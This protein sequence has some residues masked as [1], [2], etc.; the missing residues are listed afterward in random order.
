[1][2]KG[3]SMKK[4]YFLLFILFSNSSNCFGQTP[5]QTL[6]PPPFSNIYQKPILSPYVFLDS[7]F[8]MP[9]YSR[10]QP[11]I[12]QEKQQL[13]I[14]RQNKKISKLQNEIVHPNKMRST[15][16]YSE[17]YNNRINT[18]RPTGHPTYFMNLP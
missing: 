16:Q 5:Y 18:I 10:V 11:L 9:Y 8:S 6:N 1:M 7:N 3:V 4:N 12:L 13:E 15:G 14:K 17:D 2:L